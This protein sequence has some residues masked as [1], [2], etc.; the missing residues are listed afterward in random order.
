MPP[1]TT[2]TAAWSSSHERPAFT[3]AW[4][5]VDIV[6]IVAISPSLPMDPRFPRFTDKWD[7]P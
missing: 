2:G 1:L 7:E 3:M 6:T 5:S 4:S